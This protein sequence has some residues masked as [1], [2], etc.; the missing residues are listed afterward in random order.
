MEI[1]MLGHSAAGKTT[2]VSLMYSVMNTGIGGFSVRAR[3]DDDGSRLARAARAIRIGQYPAPTDQRDVFDL[4]L[5]HNGADVFPFTWRD[6]RGGTLREK[7]DSSQAR[8]LH[9][10]LKR[11]DGIVLFCDS[12]ALLNESRAGRDVRALVSHVQRAV[13]AREKR[14]TPLVIALTKADLVDLEDEK[15]I[16]RLKA[17][18]MPLAQAVAAT[19]HVVGT[20][21]P[22]ACG[23]A[24]VHVHIPV[25]WSLRF[26]II[27]RVHELEASI[28]AKIES[29]N[30]WAA[31]DTLWNRFTSAWNDE[32]PA[33]RHAAALRQQ[34]YTEYQIYE[35]LIDPANKLGGILDGVPVF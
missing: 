34:A 11:A 12:V 26:G 13:D 6:Y 5:R 14:L 20:M 4:I 35:P 29:A 1:V 10:D 28:E 32:T 9:N 3:Q 21:I 31:Q 2:Y 7:T 24:P 8:E 17:P 19:E 15:V 18:F 33:W 16:E 25:L 27:G 30:S 23:P 22:V